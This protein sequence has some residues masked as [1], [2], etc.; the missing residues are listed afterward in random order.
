MTEQKS[1]K[2]LV[3]RRMEKTGES[4]TAARAQLLAGDEAAAVDPDVLQ[5][6]CSE[7]RLREQTGRGWEEWF[8][9][10]DTWDAKSLGHTEIASRVGD[11]PGVPGW[12]AQA[13]AMSYERARG[14]RAIGQRTGSDGFVA[15]VSKTIAA[16]AE[17]VFAAFAD[18][19]VRAGWL[20]DLVLSER[21]VAQ[22]K[23]TA[24]YDVGDG[25]TRLFVTVEDKGPA[26]STIVVEQWRLADAAEREDRKDYWRRKLATLKT[27][28]EARA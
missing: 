4:Y 25:P 11:Q 15:G 5:F 7:E 13:V 23:T 22:P 9:L 26:K 27:E 20:G 14:L 24:R 6:P 2:R 17:D 18:P 10:L 21:T 16:S 28:L 1:F 3:R 8:D 12:Y 19:S